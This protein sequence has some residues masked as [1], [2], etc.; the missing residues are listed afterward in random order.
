MEKRVLN[1]RVIITPDERLG[2]N[3]PCY[4][5]YCPTLDVTSEGNT[6]E[7]A[8]A[9]VKEAM[10]LRLEVMAEEGQEIPI[11][12]EESFIINTNLWSQISKSPFPKSSR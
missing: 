3:E 2:T 10:E 6:I 4:G 9:N 11:E 12:K 1:Y 8:L 7:E 5:A